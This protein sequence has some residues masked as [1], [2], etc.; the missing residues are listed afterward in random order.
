MKDKIKK[1]HLDAWSSAISGIDVDKSVDNC[2]KLFHSEF[3]DI[4]SKILKTHEEELAEKDDLIDSFEIDMENS[5]QLLIEAKEELELFKQ[6][7]SN[8]PNKYQSLG[9]LLF[10]IDEQIIENGK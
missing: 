5:N 8:N 4:T 3:Y 6:I 2:T 9:L 7:H 10:R 1:C